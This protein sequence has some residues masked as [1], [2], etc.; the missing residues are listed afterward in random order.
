MTE[1]K[2]RRSPH[3]NPGAGTPKREQGT[4]AL[5]PGTAQ[6]EPQN[7]LSAKPHAARP[8]VNDQFVTPVGVNVEPQSRPNSENNGRSHWPLADKSARFTF[9]TEDVAPSAKVTLDVQAT[10]PATVGV[11]A[12]SFDPPHAGHKAIVDRMKAQFNLDRVYVAT[13]HA[14]GYKNM[15]SLEHR[16]AMVKLLFAGDPSVHT[17]S[18][19]MEARLGEGE[20]WDVVRTVTEQHPASR[21]FNMMGTDTFLWLRQQP[22]FARNQGVDLLINARDETVEL[23]AEVDG[24]SVGV[25]RGVDG[26]YSSTQVRNAIAKGEAS[27]ALPSQVNEYIQRHGLY[28]SAP[29]GEADAA[30][31]AVAGPSVEPKTT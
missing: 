6:S 5:Q 29:K 22:E 14:T 3:V 17:L 20:M 19:E 10:E 7:R 1:L 28:G 4:T 26:G 12:A 21:V 13:D 8:F 11:F 27:P 23:P 30:A 9:E 15:Q 2:T 24:R 25:I 16:N 18:P 31:G